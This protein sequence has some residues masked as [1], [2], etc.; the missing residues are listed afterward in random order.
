ML[1]GIYIYSDIMSDWWLLRGY[2]PLTRPIHSDIRRVNHTIGQWVTQIFVEYFYILV[3][4]WASDWPKIGH[5]YKCYAKLGGEAL[6]LFGWN[7]AGWLYILVTLWSGIFYFLNMTIFNVT[8][9][10][11]FGHMFCTVKTSRNTIWQKNNTCIELTFSRL[12]TYQ[13]LN[14]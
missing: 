2:V 14:Y 12:N 10:N 8:G 13:N 9:M 4:P 1:Y 3:K 7:W 11:R 6:H 5:L